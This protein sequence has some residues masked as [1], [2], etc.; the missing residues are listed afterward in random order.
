[1]LGLYLWGLD[2]NPNVFYS[3]QPITLNQWHHVAATYDGSQ[4]ALY[5]DGRL[6]C[7]FAASGAIATAANPLYIGS[8]QYPG[9]G[10]QWAGSIS[11][12]SIFDRALSAREIG[13]MYSRGAGKLGDMAQRPWNKGLV[14]GYHF[15]EGC[16]TTAHDFSGHDNTGTLKGDVTW[17][18][19]GVPPV[20]RCP[21]VRGEGRQRPLVRSGF[22]SRR[23]HLDGRQKSR[24]GQG[25]LSRHD[26]VCREECVCLLVGG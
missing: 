21:V 25:R 1:M 22:R 8:E 13:A 26:H 14:A 3:K 4:V 19:G 16:G 15:D 18:H 2:G 11:E 5:I 9:P 7:T 24:P 23:D 12:L 20:R 17:V 10:S 6:D